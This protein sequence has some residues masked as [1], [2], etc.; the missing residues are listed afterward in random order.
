MTPVHKLLTYLQYKPDFMMSRH[1]KRGHNPQK[2]LSVEFITISYV[3][4]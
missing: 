2:P 3:C 4:Y 1:P